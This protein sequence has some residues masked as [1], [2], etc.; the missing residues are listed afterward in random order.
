MSHRNKSGLL[1]EVTWQTG[2]AQIY[3]NS[4]KYILERE[5]KRETSTSSELEQQDAI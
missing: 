2:Q 3:R 5:K 4:R 1:P